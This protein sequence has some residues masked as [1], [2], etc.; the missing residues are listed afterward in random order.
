MPPQ[1]IGPDDVAKGEE[2]VSWRWRGDYFFPP[3]HVIGPNSLREHSLL[4]ADHSGPIASGGIPLTPF[5][6]DSGPMLLGAYPLPYPRLRY[7]PS[8]S[9]SHILTDGIPQLRNDFRREKKSAQYFYKLNQL[10][11]YSEFQSF[12]VTVM[13]PCFLFPKRRGQILLLKLHK[14]APHPRV[15]VHRFFRGTIRMTVGSHPHLHTFSERV[16]RNFFE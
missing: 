16:R 3:G 2:E 8:D 9:K 15:Q 13:T 12:C 7:L 4:P 14:H 5:Y 1:A 6:H 10:S 11:C